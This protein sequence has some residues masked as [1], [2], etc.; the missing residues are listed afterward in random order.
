MAKNENPLTPKS[1]TAQSIT[2][3]DSFNISKCAKLGVNPPNKL[4]LVQIQAK[5]EILNVKNMTPYFGVWELSIKEAAE[6]LT[7]DLWFQGKITGKVPEAESYEPNDPNLIQSL[8]DQCEKTETILLSAIN[9]GNLKTSILSQNFLT[10]QID[11]EKSFVHFLDLCSWL[12]DKDYEPGE[13]FENYYRV[14]SQIFDAAVFEVRALKSL[15]RKLLQDD[16]NWLQR[17]MYANN[18]NDSD[19]AELRRTVKI[20]SEEAAKHTFELQSMGR[21][22]RKLPEEKLLTT[23]TR[24][25]LLAIIAALCDRAEISYTE[26]GAAQRLKEITEEFGTPI[27]EKTIKSFLV[28]I[29][30]A[31]DSRTKDK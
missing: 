2:F 10:E 19:I 23:R 12:Q 28:D 5:F 17:V 15:D 21:K 30:F 4:N 3:V 7:L 18:P 25:T 1:E 13:I 11:L 6:L 24:N 27:D 14:E 22:L 20:L 16:A 9:N 26:R 31:V 8:K 29:D